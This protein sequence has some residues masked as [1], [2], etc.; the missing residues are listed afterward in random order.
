MLLTKLKQYK[1]NYQ[2]CFVFNNSKLDFKQTYAVIISRLF[3]KTGR[4]LYLCVSVCVHG[5]RASFVINCTDVNVNLKQDDKY[6]GKKLK[7]TNKQEERRRKT[8][9]P[10][11]AEKSKNMVPFLSVTKFAI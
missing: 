10:G 5:K 9:Y 1:Q 8:S 11:F 4:L 2:Y 7:K 6:F 3:T